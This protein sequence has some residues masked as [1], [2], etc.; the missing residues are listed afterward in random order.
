MAN[1]NRAM[2]DSYRAAPVIDNT[3]VANYTTNR[4]RYQYTNVPVKDKPHAAVI[5]R[6]QHNETVI[7]GAA[8]WIKMTLD[9]CIYLLHDLSL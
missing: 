7:R 2:I 4:Q 6:I 1:V 3:V 5:N 8:V 9:F